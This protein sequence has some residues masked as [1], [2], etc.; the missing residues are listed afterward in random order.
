MELR[1][2]AGYITPIL[3]LVRATTG[4]HVAGK[5]FGVMHTDIAISHQD[6]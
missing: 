2:F 5:R 6:Q 4:A 3:A 1:Q